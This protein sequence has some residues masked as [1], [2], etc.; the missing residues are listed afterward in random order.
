M[1]TPLRVLRASGLVLGR[2]SVAA[3]AAVGVMLGVLVF[4]AA[5]ALAAAPEAPETKPASGETATAAA[6]HG[7]LDPNAAS[8]ELIVEYGFFYAQRGAACNEVSFAPES[9]G[10]ASGV[11]GEAVEAALTGLEPNTEYAVCLA[12]RNPGEE[13][14]TLGNAVTFKTLPAPP[15]VRGEF[16]S[17]VSSTSAM[18]GANINPNSEATKYRFEYSES[19]TGETLSAPVVTVAGAPPAAELEGFEG[20][21]ITAATGAALTPGTTYYYRVVAENAQSET[22]PKP[23]EGKVE[24]FTTVS[25]PTTAPVTAITAS[26]ATFN[27]VLTPLN[28]NVAAEYHFVYNVGG[29]CTDGSETSQV[30]AGIGTGSASAAT[31]VTGL[32]PDTTYSVC[33]VTSN[34]KQGGVPITGAAVTFRTLPEAYVTEVTSSSV[35]LHAVLDPEGSATSYR[36][37]YGPTSEYGSETPE[38]AVGSGSA[39][40]NVEFHLQNLGAA[41]VYHYRVTD[42]NAAHETFASEDAMFTTEAAA[43]TSALPDG[44]AWE[45][46][47]PP[48]KHGAA[49]EPISLFGG[50]IQAAE[51]GG[52]ITYVSTNPPVAN[53]S[54]SRAFETSQLLSSRTSAGWSTQ[55]IATPH[56]EVGFFEIGRPAEYQWFSPDLALGLVEPRG[57]TRLAPAQVPGEVQ[58]PTLYLHDDAPLAPGASE[59]ASYAQAKANG[60][61][62]SNQGY[63]ALATKANIAEGA[64]L[65]V[66]TGS[67]GERLEFRDASPDLSHVVF[68]SPEPLTPGG[69]ELYEWGDGKLSSIGDGS[70]GAGFLRPGQHAVSNDGSRVLFTQERTEDHLYMRDNAMQ[71]ASPVENGKCTVPADACTI[72]VSAPEPG[73]EAANE[74]VFQ[75]ASSDGAKVFFTDSARL[76]GDSTAHRETPTLRDLYVFEVTSGDGEALAGRLTDLTVDPHFQQDGES[77]A[78]QDEVV[79]A[80]ENGAYVYFVANGLLGNGEGRGAVPGTPKLYLEHY[81]GSGWEAPQFIATLSGGDAPDWSG[82]T[83]RAMLTARVSPNGRYVAFMSQRSLT[84]YDNRDAVSGVPDEE[85]YLYDAETSKLACASCNP[86]G[87]R[88]SGV[89]DPNEDEPAQRLL[90]DERGA[91]DGHWLAGSVP[92]YTSVEARLAFY[93]SNYLSNNGRLFFDGAD[94]LVP[95]AVNGK[96]DVYE[97]EPVGVGG[98]AVGVAS[99]I[100]EYVAGE[101]GCVGLISAGTSSQES[102]FL[103]ASAVGGRDS[104]GAEGGGDVFFLTSSQLSS[105]DGDSAFDV[106]DAHECTA[107]S[108]CISPASTAV[109]PACSNEASCRPAPEQQPSIYGQ[110]ASATFAGPG[111]LVPAAPAP[112]AKPKTAAEIKAEKLA[113]GL[114][115]CRK[116]KRKIK[117]RNCE[118]SVRKKYGA[119][120]QAKTSNRRAK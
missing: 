40:V 108:P 2:L 26:T 52:A 105:Q 64:K 8:P 3:I 56:S 28:P 55:D 19:A 5:P 21:V 112:L 92:G 70:L 18:L 83:D 39:P 71:P 87:A 84:G 115:T 106:Y 48:D 66:G 53:P 61:A 24:Q 78:V 93:Q 120:K 95:G 59:A 42:S 37:Q 20:Q 41:S 57:E 27:G 97:W 94:G 45:L 33:F 74:P 22:E 23:A 76:T 47:S 1:C 44:R 98:C 102:A 99:A 43:S 46:V 110:P 80:S 29:A 113:K 109:T 16:S 117:R 85:V 49:I 68:R 63:L 34:E 65:A 14:W 51:D 15:S 111:N 36:F 67:V 90:V 4:S 7:V 35:T 30:D 11:K 86:M 58:E 118:A 12:A 50:A 60:E 103:D 107:S 82:N 73:G 62:M 32:Q 75:T 54:G 6:V 17:E 91:W 13:G 72:E 38:A 9:P 96:E 10:L 69:E 119:A 79:G 88:P 100:V 81:D 104:E 89:F 114:R 31:P 101:E 77:A 25:T 116:D